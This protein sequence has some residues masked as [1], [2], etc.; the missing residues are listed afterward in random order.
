MTN[1]NKKKTGLTS[2]VAGL[3]LAAIVG[4]AMGLM[5]HLA[6]AAN[7]LVGPDWVF[8]REI[9]LST[10]LLLGAAALAV[11]FITLTIVLARLLSGCDSMVADM[12]KLLA[13]QTQ[14]EAVLTNISENLLLSDKIKTI[15]FREKDR[16]VLTSAIEEDMRMER[17]S[18]AVLLIKEL[19]DRFGAAEDASR[20][21]SDL[22]RLKNATQQEKIEAAVKHIE[23]LWM[24]HHY[25]DAQREVESLLNLYPRQPEVQKLRGETEKRREEHKKE[26]LARWETAV[27]KN[28]IDQ[29]VELLKL[30]DD[31]LTP[32]E[33]AALEESAR[34][35]FKANLLNMGV[36]FK[37]F[38]T[39]RKWNQ[40]LNIG[41]KIIEEYPNSRMAQ[42]VREKLDILSERAQTSP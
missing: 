41:R 20:L 39:E 8:V 35:V 26:L 1:A 27:K 3:W 13:G 18:S 32:T 38:V 9:L 10:S 23:S 22:Q 30:L 31:Y 34:G 37:L 21:R 14:T 19:E 2:A 7:L 4:L 29:G 15:A 33:A 5:F 11:T 12:R 36:Q 42:E 17:W 24:I 25:V 16:M 40:A 28:D 6:L